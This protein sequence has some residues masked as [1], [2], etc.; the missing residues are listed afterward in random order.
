VGDL[1]GRRTE[2]LTLAERAS[3]IRGKTIT[4]WDGA[5]VVNG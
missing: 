5:E 1:L 3:A 4:C 2:A